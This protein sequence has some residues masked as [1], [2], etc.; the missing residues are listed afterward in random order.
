MPPLAY[1]AMGNFDTAPRQTLEIAHPRRVE[2]AR[3]SQVL[4]V[5]IFN[6]TGVSAGQ[7]RGR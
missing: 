3:V 5:E 2:A 4:F 1:R 6:E 7:R